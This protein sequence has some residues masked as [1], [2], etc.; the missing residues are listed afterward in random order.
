MYLYTPPIT[1]FTMTFCHIKFIY[2]VATG[3]WEKK[4]VI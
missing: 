3:S 1:T 2:T 4:P